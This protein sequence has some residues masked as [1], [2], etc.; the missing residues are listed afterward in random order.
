M[1]V[2]TRMAY[3]GHCTNKPVAEAGS[4]WL[5]RPE[6]PFETDLLNRRL[7]FG[8]SIPYCKLPRESNSLKGRLFGLQRHCRSDVG[9]LIFRICF[10]GGVYYTMIIIRSPQNPSLII[11]ALHYET[12]TLDCRPHWLTTT[13]PTQRE[14][15]THRLHSSSFL[16][17]PYNRI[18]NI[19][20]KKELQWSLY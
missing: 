17:L 6:V 15:V 4:F 7:I 8:T 11:K 1:C 13:T 5:F 16:G 9:A 3:C 12:R 2:C 10:F 18:L 14:T 19:N 20:H